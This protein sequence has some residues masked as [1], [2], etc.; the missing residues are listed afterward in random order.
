M[1]AQKNLINGGGLEMTY[2]DAAKKLA[3]MNDRSQAL[4][5]NRFIKNLYHLFD[6]RLPE[7]FES[8][9][10]CLLHSIETTPMCFNGKKRGEP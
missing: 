1:K 8:Y 10:D 6:G 5:I 7:H 2:R 4:E 9:I 3:E